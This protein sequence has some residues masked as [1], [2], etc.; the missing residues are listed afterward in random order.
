VAAFVRKPVD[1]D[2]L[3]AAINRATTP[4]LLRREIGSLS[5]EMTS[6]VDSQVGRHPLQQAV[7]GL[8]ARVAPT[9]YNVLLQGE[10]GTGKS[11]LANI[12]RAW[13]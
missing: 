4:V 6:L 13:F 9:T 2:E 11:R 3:I 1:V 10:T 8:A 7:A 12:I 5:D